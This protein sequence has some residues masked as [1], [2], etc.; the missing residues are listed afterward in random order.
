MSNTKA[1][2]RKVLV[3]LLVIVAGMFGFGFVLIPIYR[4]MANIYGFGGQMQADESDRADARKQ[5]EEVIKAGV[6][7][8]RKVTVQFMVTGNNTLDLEFRPLINQVN[9]NPGTV[10]EVKYFVKNL[11]DRKLVLKALPTVS[12]DAATKYVVRYECPC[13]YRQVLK[14]GE[15]RSMTFKLAINQAIP[16]YLQVLTLS[17]RLIE[18][19]DTAVID[20]DKLEKQARRTRDAA[21]STAL[22]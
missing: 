17:F 20:T 1:R 3:V 19:K 6:D 12:P 13:F 14:P 18:K 21:Q 2:N 16:R 8:S 7:K 9:L 15:S 4:L 5:L 10:K 22:L 11:S